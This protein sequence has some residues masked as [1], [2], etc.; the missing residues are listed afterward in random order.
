VQMGG[1]RGCRWA[2]RGW[3]TAG[4]WAANASR[5]VAARPR[6]NQSCSRSE[7]KSDSAVIN[8]NEGQPLRS[9]ARGCHRLGTANAENPPARQMHR[10]ATSSP[11]TSQGWDVEQHP[12]RTSLIGPVENEKQTVS[13]H[14]LILFLTLRVVFAR[15]RTAVA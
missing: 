13:N 1:G 4:G 15:R 14:D 8:R 6:C 7:K 12:T 9:R 3:P 5:N 2:A 11:E 10:C